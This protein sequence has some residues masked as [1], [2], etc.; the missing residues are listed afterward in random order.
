MNCNR[1]LLAANKSLVA[2]VI[3]LECV[4]WFPSLSEYRQQPIPALH[5]PCTARN[6]TFI[7][8]ICHFHCCPRLFLR[9]TCRTSDGSAGLEH[10]RVYVNVGGVTISDP[11]C[12]VTNSG[13]V[14]FLFA[15][16]SVVFCIHEI[17]IRSRK[18]WCLRLM[19]C[20]FHAQ[21]SYY[22]TMHL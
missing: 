13:R 19:I 5:I 3:L 22:S 12:N 20:H 8:F 6:I 2:R 16:F 11:D 18:Q 10:G 21:N 15:Y 17:N 7:S 9:N 1:R 4:I 14:M